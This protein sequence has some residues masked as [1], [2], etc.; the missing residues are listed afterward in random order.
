[1]N[2]ETAF[3]EW[4]KQRKFARSVWESKH[5]SAM[6]WGT[7]LHGEWIGWEQ[8]V[9]AGA[10]W[11]KEQSS[12]DAIEFAIW[13]HKNLWANIND[14][15]LWYNKDKVYQYKTECLTSQQLYELWQKSKSKSNA[16]N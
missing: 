8:G 2:K 1:M 16:D 7:P 3:K 11:Q 4:E 12:T 10:E 6:P 5:G 13:T 9:I 14:E 15:P